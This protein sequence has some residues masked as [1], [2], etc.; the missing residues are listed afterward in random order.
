MAARALPD[1]ASGKFSP[2]ATIALSVSKS[3]YLHIFK[4]VSYLVCPPILT[5]LLVSS[6]GTRVFTWFTVSSPTEALPP[7]TNSL[8]G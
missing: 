6:E 8:L 5:I 3:K 2:F 7:I 4:E 1:N